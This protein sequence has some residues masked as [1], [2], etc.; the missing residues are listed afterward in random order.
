M[1][2]HEEGPVW[3][4]SS[5]LIGLKT[6]YDGKSKPSESCL[7][8]LADKRWIPVC[9]EQLGGLATPRNP[10][11]IIGGD[12]MDV[13]NGKASL[14]TQTGDDVSEAFLA[15][16]EQVFKICELQ[17][18]AGMCVKSRSP[19]CGLMEILGVTSAYLLQKG[20]VLKEF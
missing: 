3:L 5:C 17:E 1:K 15:G 16:A 18:V 8:F 11:I 12:G 6:R 14:L 7:Q 13:I 2:K 9:P 19:S 10:A 4:V 20:I